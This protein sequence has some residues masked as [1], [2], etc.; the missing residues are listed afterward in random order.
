[1]QAPSCAIS[2]SLVRRCLA[3]AQRRTSQHEARVAALV[4]SCFLLTSIGWMLWMD[5][6][7]CFE[8]TMSVEFL[9]LVV[10]YAVQ[11]G[12]AAAYTA[13]ARRCPTRITSR[14]C[15]AAILLFVTALLPVVFGSYA[16]VV[17]FGMAANLLCGML[18]AHYVTR[19]AQL[20]AS[21]RRATV[22][23]GA[24]AASTVASWLLS[25]VATGLVQ[26]VP[27]LVSCCAL[28]IPA[29]CATMWVERVA[30]T[31]P[32][33]T[34]A[35]DAPDGVMDAMTRTFAPCLAL[36]LL[37]SVTKNL[38]FGFPVQDLAEGVDLATS[39][40]FY[41]AGL[42]GAGLVFDRDRSFGMFFCVCS[43]ML[44]FVSLALVGTGTSA[45]TIWALSYLLFG[46]FSVYRVV[47]VADLASSTQQVWL[48][49]AGLMFG[50][51]GDA[52]GSYANLALAS[53]TVALVALAAISFV[54]T[55]CVARHV[56]RSHASAESP[57]PAPAP[58]EPP[59]IDEQAAFEAYARAHDL[60][61]R[62]QEVLRL[63]LDGL[64]NQQIGT[65]LVVSN[66]T[67]K[68]HVRNVLHKTGCSN[69]A[70]LQQSYKDSKR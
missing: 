10:S 8:S 25:H 6:L 66:N 43:L 1:M 60:S 7:S 54:A 39:R 69:R 18:Q 26:G 34:G 22:F 52:L 19:L 9:T 70:E 49:S 15:T 14:T 63:M 5:E 32:S 2:K 36:V 67:V 31:D 55:M 41:G 27:G 62:Q 20:V 21:E 13:Y 42:L 28:A 24:Y 51:L 17:G 44:P 23:G 16:T 29:A 48:A 30:Q 50:R 4:L 38:G 68:F 59:A 61:N 12:G 65:K 46:F 11:A 45:M 64:T 35:S 33:D 3:H 56:H 37:M 58:N 40:L 57:E 53:N 47:L